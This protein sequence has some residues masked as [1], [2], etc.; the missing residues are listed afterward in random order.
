MKEKL[1]NMPYAQCE[2]VRDEYGAITLVSYT[3]AVINIDP[4]GWLTCSGLYSMT[5]RKHISAFMKVYTDLTFADA[6]KC[7]EEHKTVN[8]Y[9]HKWETLYP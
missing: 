2:V 5:T 4:E 3:T 8:I 1:S 6:K 9:S 7:Y